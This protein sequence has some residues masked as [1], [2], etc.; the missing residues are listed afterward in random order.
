VIVPGTVEMVTVY[1]EDS[2]VHSR[3]MNSAVRHSLWR[4]TRRHD[5]AFRSWAAAQLWRP[6]AEPVSASQREAP[7]CSAE[8]HRLASEPCV[9][10]PPSA[11]EPGGE[12]CGAT[13]MQIQLSR[14]GIDAAAGLSYADIQAVLHKCQRSCKGSDVHSPRSWRRAAACVVI[15]I[16]VRRLL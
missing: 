11:E 4:F 5:A 16:F 8:I 15:A 6:T 7:E 12:T 2:K 10:N 1:F 3:V 9:P 14:R 13:Q